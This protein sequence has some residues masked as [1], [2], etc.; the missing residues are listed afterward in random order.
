MADGATPLSTQERLA[1][2]IGS[3]ALPDDAMQ[4]AKTLLSRLQTPVRVALL[5]LPGS[6]KSTLLNMLVGTE[7]I[8][9]SIS[10][11]T[12]ELVKGTQPR[13]TLTLPNGDTKVLDDVNARTISGY[14]PA[15]VNLEMDLPA[16]GKISILELVTSNAREEQRRALI[17]ACKRTD[18]AL[19]CTQDFTSAEQLLWDLVPDTIKDHAFLLRTKADELG[20]DRNYVVSDLTSFAGEQF[21]QVLPLSA[22]EAI[23]ARAPDGTVDKPRL[24]ASGGMALISAILR[25]VDLGR[26]YAVDQADILLR[27]HAVADVPQVP[28]AVE[29]PP[30]AK[31]KPAGE[32]KAKAEKPAKPQ[33]AAAPVGL[34][35]DG[36][37]MLEAAVARLTADAQAMAG[38]KDIDPAD[39]M[40]RAVASVQWLEDHLT[41][42]GPKDDSVLSLARATISD[43]TELIQ[44]MEIEEQ[45]TGP[46]EAVT[47]MIQLRRNL[48]TS[49][50]A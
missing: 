10:L 17:W 7:V 42:Q 13:A 2:A 18:I 32:G 19:W 14:A 11:P 6:G 49:L 43:A 45:D 36:R 8:P 38:G 50:C 30:V 31:A 35:A 46:Q 37:K 29:D 25:Q 34:T 48:V 44:L 12:L 4:T 28:P 41:N 21:A 40:T 20:D 27:L 22:T 1:A 26:Q 23:A 3:G 5:G 15:F 16:L 9:R 47:L 24:R 33:K 39:I